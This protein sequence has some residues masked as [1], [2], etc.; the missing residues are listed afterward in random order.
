MLQETMENLLHPPALVSIVLL[1]VVLYFGPQQFTH[2]LLGDYFNTAITLYNGFLL[3]IAYPLARILL[4][5]D[6]LNDSNSSNLNRNRN[7]SGHQANGLGVRYLLDEHRNATSTTFIDR[8]KITSRAMMMNI[9]QQLDV[10]T[11]TGVSSLSNE[12]SSSSIPPTLQMVQGLVN[13]GNSCFLNSVLQA[14]SSLSSLQPY[15]ESLLIRADDL[16]VAIEDSQV[17]EALLETIESL[18]E[19][20]SSPKSFRPRTFVAALEAARSRD[21]SASGYNSNIM[22]RDQQDAQELFQI[23]SSAL[24]SE[25]LGLR[26]LEA[27]RPLMD[28]DLVPSLTRLN[29]NLA[30]TPRVK[31]EPSNPMVGMLASRLSCI[32]CGYTEAIRHFTFDNLSLSIPSNYSCTIEDCLQKFVNLE[33]LNDAA[34]RKCSLLATLSRL[35]EEVKYLD[36]LINKKTKTTGTQPNQSISNNHSHHY[37]SSSTSLRQRKKMSKARPVVLHEQFSSDAESDLEY[38]RTTVTSHTSPAIT[39]FTKSELTAKKASIVQQQHAL[40]TA[41]RT[42]VQAPLPGITLTKTV[43]PH[44]TKQVMIGKAPRVL[45]LHFQRSQY[46]AYGTVSKNNCRITFPEYLD[47]TP[48]S[49]SG[50]LLTKPNVPMSVSD[51]ELRQMGLFGHDSNANTRSGTHSTVM[52]MKRSM[53]K[54]Q[55]VVVHYGGHSYGHFIAYRRKP[56]SMVSRVEQDRQGGSG[57]AMGRRED[58]FRVS[59]ETV[60]ST[61]LEDVLSAN[62][63]MCL[64]EKVGEEEDGGLGNEKRCKNTLPQALSRLSLQAVELGLGRLLGRLSKNEGVLVNGKDGRSRTTLARTATTTTTTSSSSYGGS[65]GEMETET[66]TEASS[67]SPMS[68][69]SSLTSLSSAKD[70]GMDMSM[71]SDQD[72]A[73]K[74]RERLTVLS[75]ARDE[76]MSDMEHLQG[77][78]DG[79][80]WHSF[81]SSP[82]S[83]TPPSPM[84]G[85]C[86]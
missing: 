71:M 15:L 70:S 5:W 32:Q 35:R 67:L 57:Y 3:H 68:V 78:E 86:V 42:D 76:D 48:F 43:S 6:H 73:A 74:F 29:E 41:I 33:S 31:N 4:G 61:T 65:D 27:T 81:V 63:Y 19:P 72:Y 82:N 17:A 84:M 12:R 54:L 1:A 59:D 7:R 38:D 49:T 79:H 11:A 37:N 22:N 46:S 75:K 21:P 8:S 58:W 69:S 55:S 50:V 45:C 80:P 62:P 23:V 44:C 40:L 34:C 9:Q 28:A 14:L 52:P 25:E 18:K 10:S 83:T 13:T 60:E 30:P 24:S 77:Q 26:T 85:S 39:Q 53:Y 56:A 64:Y 51:H 47:L 66:D 36:N 2:L 20:Q 16:K